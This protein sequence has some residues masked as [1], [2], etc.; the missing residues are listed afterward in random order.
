MGNPVTQFVI[1]IVGADIGTE[2]N[3]QIFLLEQLLWPYNME[4]NITTLAASAN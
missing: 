2:D 4:Q 3:N 1:T